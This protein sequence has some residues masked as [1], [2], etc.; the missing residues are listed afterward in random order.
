MVQRLG[1]LQPFMGGIRAQTDLGSQENGPRS[2]GW[3]SVK[4]KSNAKY[5]IG[6]YCLGKTTVA[7]CK[8]SLKMD[9]SLDG[10]LNTNVLF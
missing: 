10:T 2:I 7:H 1:G 9:E 3:K 4:K 8:P 5:K 6:N